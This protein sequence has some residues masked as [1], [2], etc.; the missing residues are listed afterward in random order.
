MVKYQRLSVVIPAGIIPAPV[1]VVETMPQFTNCCPEP[2][3][4][5]KTCAQLVDCM[6][7]CSDFAQVCHIANGAEADGGGRDCVEAAKENPVVN[8]R[9]RA[10]V[11]GRT[12]KVRVNRVMNFTSKRTLSIRIQLQ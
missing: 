12:P 2:I 6:D 4:L 3:S 8:I 7:T 9:A 5:G 1:D 11:P 10:A